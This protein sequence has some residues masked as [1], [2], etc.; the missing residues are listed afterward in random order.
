MDKYIVTFEA[1]D[2]Q[3]QKQDVDRLVAAAM[4]RFNAHTES[5]RVAMCEDFLRNPKNANTTLRNIA[6][7]VLDEYFADWFQRP[8][9]GYLLVPSVTV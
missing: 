9:E 6:A 1:H 7:K 5:E 4:K 3:S 2:W 8:K